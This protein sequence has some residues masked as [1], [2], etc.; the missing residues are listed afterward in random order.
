M[1]VMV[2]GAAGYIGSN[3]CRVL[4]EKGHDVFA[5]DN[6]SNSRQHSLLRLRD[7]YPGRVTVA[8]RTLQAQY[9]SQLPELSGVVHLA[10]YKYVGESVADPLRYWSN[11]LNSTYKAVEIALHNRAPLVF[12]SSASVYGHGPVPMREDSPL[13]PASPYGRSKLACE[14]VI[15]DAV[16]AHGLQA[17]ALRYFNPVGVGEGGLASEP[18]T[19]SH[20]FESI[21]KA[22]RERLPV[23]ING[24]DY[25]TVDGTVERDYV[26]VEDLAEVH[27][28][29]LEYAGELVEGSFDALNVGTGA[30]TSIHQIVQAFEKRLGR[31]LPIHYGDRRPGDPARSYAAVD[32][33]AHRLNWRATRTVEDA[34]EDTLRHYGLQPI[35]KDPA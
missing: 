32:R 30:P 27:L 22:L 35:A 31:L 28:L 16:A 34:V 24:T 11:N 3:V 14:Q 17:V 8:I 26:H 18:P 6:L 9:P 20:L 19:P 29:A 13:T 25:P 2:T 5:L 1:T 4:L 15:R 7:Q 10:G 23:T 12:S 33:I 21:V